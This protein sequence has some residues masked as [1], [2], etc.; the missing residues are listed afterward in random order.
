MAIV[1]EDGTGLANSNSYASEA[2]LT[3]YATAR[4]V[5]ISGTNEQLLIQAMDFI[6]QQRFIGDKASK[7]QALQWPRTGAMVD[8]YYIDSDEIP[9]LLKEAQMEVSL[10]IDS[11]FNPMSSLERETKREKIDGAIEVEY[12]SGAAAKTVITAAVT[13]LNKLTRQ[14]TGV[15]RA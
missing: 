3:A 1:V 8:G 11:G 7:E 14:L 12:A 15:I 10:S 5:T 2:D 6:E 4:G 13:R 9:T